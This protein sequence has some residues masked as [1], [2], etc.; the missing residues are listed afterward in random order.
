MSAEVDG[1]R[2]DYEI[3]QAGIDRSPTN[4]VIGRAKDSAAVCNPGE[5]MFTGVDGERRDNPAEIGLRPTIAVIGG[6]KKSAIRSYKNIPAGTN[7]KRPDKYSIKAICLLPK[8][9]GNHYDRRERKACRQNE[10]YDC[11]FVHDK[12]P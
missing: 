7:G 2:Q 9:L 10:N 1:K 5:N 12:S 8:I 6:A 3:R 11:N 4:A